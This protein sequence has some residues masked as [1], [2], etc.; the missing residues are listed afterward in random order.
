M[1]QIAFIAL[2]EC[3]ASSITLPME[4][5][6]AADTIART[7]LRRP[8]KLNMVVAG[9][10][11][12]PVTTSG[13]ASFNVN[14]DY[15]AIDYADLIVL[16]ALWRNPLQVIR[17]HREL[18]A[19]IERMAQ[20]DNTICAVGTSSFLLAEAGLLTQK[21]ATTHWYY[22]DTFK[23]RYPKVLLKREFLIT[24]ADNLY[25][26]GSVNSIADLTIHLIAGIFSDEIARLVEAQFS[27]EIRRPF[28]SHAYAQDQNNHHQDELVIQAQEWLRHHCQTNSNI[29]ALAHSLGLSI[30]SFNRRFKQAT[31]TTASDYLQLQRTQ[32]AKELLRTSNLSISEIAAHCGYNDSSHFCA[33]FKA[34]TNQT[35]LTYRKAVR[36]KLFHVT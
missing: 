4:M 3:L 32:I 2:P 17:R 21:P 10:G 28:E 5:L 34:S 33:R 26:A 30:R 12:E 9:D 35:P 6:N 19:W 13:G 25:C 1:F 14:C 15:R 8:A 20:T 27:P 16:P 29:S 18:L 11:R 24:Q 31:G 36:G 23:K 22:L 7:Q